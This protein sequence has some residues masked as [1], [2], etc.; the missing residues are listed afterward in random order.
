RTFFSIPQ[1]FW[2]SR[3]RAFYRRLLQKLY[4]M[5]PIFLVQRQQVG[6]YQTAV[7]KEKH[8]SELIETQEDFENEEEREWHKGNYNEIKTDELEQEAAFQ[9][10]W[11]KQCNKTDA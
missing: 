2:K 10:E 11:A 8:G 9:R 3:G 4:K 6:T 1:R 7:D 5:K